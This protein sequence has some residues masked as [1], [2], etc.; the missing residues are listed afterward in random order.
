MG[1]ISQMC[2]RLCLSFNYV[3]GT[4]FFANRPCHTVFTAGI[5]PRPPALVVCPGMSRD[6]EREE[7][8]AA[9]ITEDGRLCVFGTRGGVRCASPGVHRWVTHAIE[10]AIP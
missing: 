7:R 9:M 10:G 3:A 6:D 1:H 8:Y 5:P 4:A 2:A